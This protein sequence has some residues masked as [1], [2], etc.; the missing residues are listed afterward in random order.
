MA[1]LKAMTGS[2]WKACLAAI[3]VCAMTTAGPALAQVTSV[4]PDKAIDALVGGRW[5]EAVSG[6]PEDN[7]DYLEA[8]I[9]SVGASCSTR[10]CTT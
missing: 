4:D 2:G 7:F 6:E 8:R 3:A 1:M 5:H 9:A 10:S